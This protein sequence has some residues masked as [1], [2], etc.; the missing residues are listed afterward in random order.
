MDDNEIV[1]KHSGGVLI[2]SA[3]PYRQSVATNEMSNPQS[4]T[5][6]IRAR[7]VKA[8]HPLTIVLNFTTLDALNAF[9]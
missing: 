9:H 2:S 1:L 3:T 5:L 8:R 6:S 4:D 7:F